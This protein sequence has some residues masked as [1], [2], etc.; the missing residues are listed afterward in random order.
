MSDQEM[1]K[2]RDIDATEWES[3]SKQQKYEKLNEKEWKTSTVPELCKYPLFY[4]CFC[5]CDLWIGCILNQIATSLQSQTI[6]L[7]S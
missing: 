5:C 2:P 6:S 7:P 4:R 3:Y 1:R